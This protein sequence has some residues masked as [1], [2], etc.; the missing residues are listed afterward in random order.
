MPKPKIPE[1]AF[2]T[3]DEAAILLEL[4]DRT[5]VYPYLKRL[6][7]TRHKFE[8]DRRRYIASEDLDRIKQFKSTESWKRG[9]LVKG[10]NPQG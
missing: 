10:E 1:K 5:S 2:Y 3:I 6:N 4:G 8:W 9:D 7:I